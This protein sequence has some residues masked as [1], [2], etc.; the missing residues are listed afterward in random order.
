MIR[1]EVL[2]KKSVSDEIWKKFMFLGQKQGC[3]KLTELA[4]EMNLH[5]EETLVF[6][7]QIF[8]AGSGVEIFF[9][10]D[11][12]WLDFKNDTTNYILP[13][14][15]FEWILLY[16]MLGSL[17]SADTTLI[18]SLKKK[19]IDFGPFK[20][21]IDLLKQL[22]QWDI[23][24]I[25]RTLI[26]D[27]DEAIAKSNLVKITTLEEKKYFIH[28]CKVIHIEGSLSLIAEDSTDRCL[29]VIP[30][31][32]IQ[33]LE[34]IDKFSALKVSA[35]EIEEFITAIRSMGEMETRLILKIYDHQTINLFPDHHFLGKPCMV[36]NP[37]G[38]LIWAAYVEPCDSLYEWILSLGKRVEIL[39]PLNFRQKYLSYCEEKLKKIA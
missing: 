25:D 12:C 3:I 10:Q 36:T 39:D 37:N 34:T 26:K 18:S 7:K 1:K 8:P 32:N 30:L 16:Q 27:L 11:E 2:M 35:Y 14:T 6:M 13:L 31:R 17:E 23:T 9:K 5:P 20:M 19:L 24:E 21:S 28:P 29:S 22:Q 33:T 38:D 15:S 4:H